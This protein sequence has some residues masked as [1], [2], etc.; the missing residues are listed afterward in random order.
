MLLLV[1]KMTCSV[2]FIG[3]LLV[4]EDDMKRNPYLFLLSLLLLSLP[5]LSLLLL[6]LLLPLLLLIIPIDSTNG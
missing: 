2:T 3:L 6:L 5:L 4:V 1:L